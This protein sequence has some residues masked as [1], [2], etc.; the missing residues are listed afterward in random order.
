LTVFSLDAKVTNTSF[1]SIVKNLSLSL[2][3]LD[4]PIG[5]RNQEDMVEMLE[6]RSM[7]K[8]ELLCLSKRMVFKER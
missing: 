6:L 2:E 1:A 5:L 8:L 3:K 4:F 7:S